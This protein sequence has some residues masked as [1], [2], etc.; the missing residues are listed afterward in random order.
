VYVYCAAT[1]VCGQLG[2]V[3]WKNWILKKRRCLGTLIEIA[4]P[5][6]AIALL[7]LLRD[8]IKVEDQPQNL[9][10]NQAR[11]VGYH[12]VTT[13]FYAMGATNNLWE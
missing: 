5:V 3:L 2:L 12:T 6:L 8:L 4:V 9:L 11:T 7:I 10:V 13:L 1:M